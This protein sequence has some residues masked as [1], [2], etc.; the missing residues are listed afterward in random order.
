MRSIGLVTVAETT[1]AVTEH[2]VYRSVSGTD[3]G[4]SSGWG[5]GGGSGSVDLLDRLEAAAVEGP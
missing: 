1:T 3:H 2:S 4:A 5:G